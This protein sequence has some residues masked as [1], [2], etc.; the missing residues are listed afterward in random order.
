VLGGA[1]EARDLR[2]GAVGEE[3]EEGERADD[4]SAGDGERGQ[5]LGA[6]V[7]DHGGVGEQVERL[8]RERAEGGQGELENFPVVRGAESREAAFTV[9]RMATVAIRPAVRRIAGGIH[10]STK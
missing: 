3:V 5:L 2:R 6:E 8:R 10:S 1:G 4:E 9:A 7:A